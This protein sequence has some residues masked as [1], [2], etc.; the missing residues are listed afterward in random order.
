MTSI[1]LGIGAYE[2]L[3]AGE[4]LVRLVNRFV[5]SNPTNL[6]EKSSL[7]SRP[8]T[9]SLTQCAGGLIRGNYSK[10][11]MFSDDLFT[12]SGPNISRFSSAGVTIPIAGVVAG[13]G[14]PYFTWMKG[15]GYE[16][17]FI[18]DGLTLQ[19]YTTHA[20]GLLTA[21]AITSQVI[22]I[23]GT[24][25][26]WSATVDGGT[27]AGTSANPWRALLGADLLTSLASMA[28]LLNFTGLSGLDYS[29]AL[30]G[31][32]AL[33]TATAQNTTLT[34]TAIPDLSS[35]NTITTSVFSGASMSW[36]AA[37][38]TGGGNQALQAVAMP[39]PSE[40]P[41]ALATV[42][43]FVLVSV[44]N[45]QKVYFILPGETTIDPK[46]F[47]EKESNPD[48]VEDMHT[49]GDSVVITGGTSTENWYATGDPTAPF[50]PIEGRVYRRGT[51]P[52]TPVVVKDALILVGD[53]CVVY[54]IGYTYGASGGTW[55]VNRISNHGI[56]ER[57]RTQI[58][59]IQGLPS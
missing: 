42:S 30:P 13:T 36:G 22:E 18:A 27:P 51:I 49:V 11:G 47:F 38:L 10:I 46:N 39:D 34:L 29:T 2:R 6:K 24:Y 55:G 23:G 44:G 20:M 53:D 8:G 41:K 48:N 9:Q 19:Y 7:L 43:S 40:V 52:G 50:L 58:R 31:P 32:S 37:S 3:Y 33:V 28:Q 45:S 59:R 57:I 25:Y 1:P 16:F 15:I 5:E 54:S 56:E 14:N 26:T 17:A 4:P 21:S 35:G 12:V